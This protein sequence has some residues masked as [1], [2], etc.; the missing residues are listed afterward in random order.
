MAHAPLARIVA[1]RGAS[2]EAPENT[3]GALR[4]AASQ[5]AQCVEIDVSISADNV[6]FVHHDHTLERCTT[7][8]GLLCEHYAKDLDTLSAGINVAGFDDEPL[9]RLSAVIELLIQHKMG[10]NLEIKPHA[11]LEHQTAEAV[12]RVISESWPSDLPLVFS[13]FQHEC[14]EVTR[15][16]L[17]EVARAPLVGA[18][19][20]SWQALMQQFDAQNIHCAASKLTALHAHQVVDAGYGLYCYTVNSSSD[21]KALFDLG[22]HGVFTDFPKRLL[23]A[24]S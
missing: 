23:D 20:D 14:L 11:G 5:G 24:E 1:H 4:L 10:L 16:L 3:L 21:A 2:G 22:V 7:G 17:P 8:T 6:P 13:C 18:V 15:Q 9:P 19:P 12:C